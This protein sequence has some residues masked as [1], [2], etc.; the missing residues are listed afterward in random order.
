MAAEIDGDPFDANGPF[1]KSLTASRM[2]GNANYVEDIRIY[3]KSKSKKNSETA[4]KLILIVFFRVF[5]LKKYL[6]LLEA[7]Y[8]YSRIEHN[9]FLI[10][11]Q[12]K[13]FLNTSKRK[14]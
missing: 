10:N 4:F 9:T 12:F 7:F 1:Y 3:T 11:R 14:N 6:I 5:G 8:K 2:L 13:K